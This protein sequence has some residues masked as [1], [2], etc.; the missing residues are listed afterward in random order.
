MFGNLF[1]S[2]QEDP[3]TDLT[4]LD[5]EV[6]YILDYFLKSWEVKAV[7]EYDWGNNFFT[8]EYKLDSGDEILFLHIEETE[9]GLECVISKKVKLLEIDEDLKDEILKYDEPKSKKIFYKERKYRLGDENQ[10][11]FRDTA[12]ENWQQFVSWEYVSKDGENI[13]TIERWGEMEFEA[14]SGTYVEAHEF[15]NFLPRE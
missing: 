15:S 9:E 8:I 11:F 3:K 7:Y 2:K 12:S 14:S 6:G 1:K 5:L 4:I 10:G 13:I